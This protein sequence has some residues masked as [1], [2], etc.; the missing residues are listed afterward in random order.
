M[1]KISR[2]NTFFFLDICV[3]ETCEK[4]VYKYSEAIEYVKN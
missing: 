1:W 2:K 3:L 4:F